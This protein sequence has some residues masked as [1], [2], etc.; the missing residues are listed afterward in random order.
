M[1]NENSLIFKIEPRKG[2]FYGELWLTIFSLLAT[3]GLFLLIA[4][5]S[6]YNEILSSLG[7][8]LLLF[9]SLATGVNIK[10]LTEFKYP[11]YYK[12]NDSGIE[13]SF[14][15]NTNMYEWQN[16]RGWI[17]S[18]KI[19]SDMYERGMPG[20]DDVV[21]AIGFYGKSHIKKDGFIHLSFINGKNTMLEIPEKYYAE[22]I[23]LLN[24]YSKN[25]TV[26]E[27][28]NRK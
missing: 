1:E 7:F 27:F 26:N 5:F 9:F 23:E 14:D 15:E 18:S 22:T 20:Q 21:K 16:I 2:R 24:K 17:E 19:D 10:W 25:L 11:R 8:G 6:N 4:G 28:Y 3:L 13:Y 12:I